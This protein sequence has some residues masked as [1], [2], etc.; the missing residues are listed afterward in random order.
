[1][2]SSRFPRQLD[3]FEGRGVLIAIVIIDGG[4]GHDAR[5]DGRTVGIGVDGYPARRA[6]R[7][8]E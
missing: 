7:R 3:L 2:A 4:F 1:V 5:Q 8:P 6:R